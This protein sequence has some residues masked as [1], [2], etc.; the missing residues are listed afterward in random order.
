MASGYALTADNLMGQTVIGKTAYQV[1]QL[2]AKPELSIFAR[3]G[4][5]GPRG[6]MYLVTDYGPEFRLNSV[7]LGGGVSW[8]A[9]PRELRGLTRAALSMFMGGETPVAAGSVQ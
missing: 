7:C 9:Q 6:S 2:P 4:L 8:T 5:V 3:F 1:Y